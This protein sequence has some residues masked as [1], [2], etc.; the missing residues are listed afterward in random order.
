MRQRRFL[1]KSPHIA[2]I[3]NSVSNWPVEG[4]DEGQG[5][6]GR[7]QGGTREASCLAFKTATTPPRPPPV[8]PLTLQQVYQD[9]CPNDPLCY[10]FGF[11]DRNRS[12][13]PTMAASLLYKLV[14]N[15]VKP[16]VTIDNNLW[17]EVYTSK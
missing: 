3:G 14:E 1:D 12:P 10:S 11:Y 9:I 6:G 8:F 5:E 4:R 7:G 16:G 17:R 15:N 2:R 13:T